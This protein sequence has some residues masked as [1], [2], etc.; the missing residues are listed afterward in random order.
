[1]SE[2]VAAFLPATQRWFRTALGAP[3]PPQ[4]LGWPAIQRG[5][6]TLILSPTGSGK[7]LAAFL[8]GIDRIYRDL[9]ADPSLCGVKLLD[10]SPLMALNN[11]IARNLREP[12]AG[13]RAAAE[14]LGA[15]LPPLRIAV[16]TGDTPSSERQRMVRQPPHILITTPESL[17]LILTSPKARD[18][19]PTVQCVIVDEIH[20]LCGEKRGVHLALSLERL[21]ALIG[22]PFQ[23]IGLSATQRPLEEVARFLGGSAWRPASDGGEELVERPVTIVDAGA[24]KALDVRII[25]AVPDLRHMVGDSIWLSVVP[26]VLNTVRRHHTTLIFVNGRRAAERAAD[27]LNEQYALKE[28]EVVP[29]GS[30]AALLRDGVPVGQGLF[31]T[32]RVDGPFRAHHGSV[33]RDVRLELETKLKAGAL[34]AL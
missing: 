13:I 4:A 1:M 14:A 24:R 18:I 21:G 19:L 30:P 20:T 31:G 34:P 23:R 25:T 26:D 28:A 9:A 5:E 17:Y 6:H 33:S 16:R 22:R 12:L 7:T 8:W 32:G 10:I 27:R 11:D 15:P 3:T 2:A 29:P